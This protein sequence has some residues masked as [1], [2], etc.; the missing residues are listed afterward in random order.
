MEFI[1][2]LILELAFEGSV[3][4][5]KSPKLPKYIRYSLIALITLFFLAV[6]GIIFFTGI[7]LL[8]D[9]LLAGSLITGIGFVLVICAIIKF[10]KIYLNRSDKR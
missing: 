3:E 5:V 6:I 8:K 4:A 7:L 9:N 10:K 1:I 2:E